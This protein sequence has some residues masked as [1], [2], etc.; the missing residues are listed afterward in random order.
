MPL[1]NTSTHSAPHSMVQSWR[2]PPPG[3]ENSYM[4]YASNAA[5]GVP[6]GSGSIES[7]CSQFQNRL[8]RTGQFWTKKGFTALLRIL[9]RHWNGELDS[10]WRASAA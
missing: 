5:Q 10:P 1:V 8:K 4:D 9:V 3:V 6:I 7:L 2:K